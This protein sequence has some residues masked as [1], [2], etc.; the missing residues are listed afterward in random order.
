MVDHLEMP[1]AAAG[2][3]I[4]SQKAI[5]EKIIAVAVGAIK[6]VLGAR[7]GCV[8][9]A[10]LLVQCEF[11]PDVGSAD[12]SP[13]VLGP[14]LIA[15]FAGARN[16]VEGPDEFSGSH[17]E[18]ADVTWGR[19]ITLVGGRANDQLV[20]EDPARRR[21]LHQSEGSRIAVETVSQ[22]HR[23]VRAEGPNRLASTGIDSA[24]RLIRAKKKTPVRS[25]SE[26]SRIAVETVSQIHRAVRAEG[27]NRLAST[28]IDSAKRLIRAKK[29]TPVRAVPALPVI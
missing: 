5:G 27:P 12:R 15:E 6:V 3:G 4:E 29:K 10:V 22:I 2:A 26:G 25:Q 20:L 28:G 17:V 19:A 8:N 21:G 16:C 1:D 7:C 14:G 23:A 11:T 24:K 18:C 13:R 9:H